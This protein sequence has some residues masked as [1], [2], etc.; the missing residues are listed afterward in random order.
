MDPILDA[1]ALERR[2]LAGDPHRPRYHFLPPA[3]W[4]NDP[5]GMIQWQGRYHLFYQHNP[6]GPYWG[7]IHWGHAISDD[8]VRWED[9]PIALAPTPGGPDKDGCWSG[10]AVDNDGIPTLLYTGVWPEVV[11]L[12]TSAD[13]LRTWAKPAGNPVIAGP[14]AG[15]ETTGFRDPCVWREAGAWYMALGSGIKDAGGAVLLYRSRDLLRWDYVHP[16]LVGDGAETGVMWECPSFFAL[17]DRHVLLVSVT[18]HAHTLCFVGTYQNHRF[19]PERMGRLDLGGCFYAPQTM[20]D[21]LGRRIM[22]GWL[23][24]DRSDDAQ[25]AAGWA[26]VQSLPRVLALQPD[27]A[28]G[29][30]PLPA[31]RTLRGAH[32]HLTDVRLPPAADEALPGIQ[33]DC[34]EIRAE[35]EPGSAGACGVALRR[36]PDG[37]EA[38]LV[39]YDR[40][41]GRLFIDRARASQREDADH[42][43]EGGA[44]DLRDSEALRL[45][46]FLDRSVVEVFA[47]GRACLTSRVYPTRPDSLG[48]GLFARGAGATVRAL[49]AWT[50]RSIWP[51]GG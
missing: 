13:D 1:A 16:L 12:A 48:V 25:R 49:D 3:N 14:P 37:A 32:H 31:L 50:V 10:C 36:A 21:D 23:N 51:A 5:N 41:A 47:N 11:C 2:R 6:D 45:H 26:G 44:L 19:S 35:F 43:A 46:I 40:S 29:M 17:G 15:L 27:G 30:E 24:E 39:G 8:L 7:N 28:L 33:G 42:H 22:M 38:T 4:M 18:P 34:L 20:R 9:W